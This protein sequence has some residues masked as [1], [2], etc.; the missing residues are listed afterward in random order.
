MVR[1]RQTVGGHLPGFRKPGNRLLG[2]GVV[3]GERGETALGDVTRRLFVRHCGVER[4]G[5]LNT[6]EDEPSSMAAN[7]GRL[8]DERLLGKR[9]RIVVFANLCSS[10]A[11]PGARRQNHHKQ[12]E[13]EASHYSDSTCFEALEHRS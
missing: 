9:M 10:P 3:L 6:S 8:D 12:H 7:R 5:V 2:N 11:A 4:A 13:Y 1:P